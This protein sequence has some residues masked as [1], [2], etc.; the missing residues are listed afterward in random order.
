ME[1]KIN[2]KTDRNPE[3]QRKQKALEKEKEA[4]AAA[5]KLEEKIQNTTDKIN[6]LNAE[7]SI[8]KRKTKTKEV[9]VEAALVDIKAE[10]TLLLL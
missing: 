4:E 7:T 2:F 3:N 10:K 5:T 9:L 1:E 8:A 6:E